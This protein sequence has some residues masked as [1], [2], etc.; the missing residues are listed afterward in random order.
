M[1]LIYLMPRGKCCRDM[2][3]HY[4]IY[5]LSIITATDVLALHVGDALLSRAWSVN[6]E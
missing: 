5:W 2:P 1:C 4:K 6:Q 3:D